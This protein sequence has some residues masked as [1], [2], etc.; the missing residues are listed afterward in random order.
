MNL[1]HTFALCCALTLA[2][3]AEPAWATQALDPID[4]GLLDLGAR[5]GKTAQDAKVLANAEA[6]FKAAAKHGDPE[7]NLYLAMTELALVEQNPAVQTLLNQLGVS[8][9]GRD[10]LNWKA[11]MPKNPKLNI[12][13]SEFEKLAANQLLT[14]LASADTK[15]AL[16]GS[17]FKTIHDLSQAGVRDVV[18]DY[19]DVSL[20][21][22]LIHA[23]SSGYGVVMTLISSS[24]TSRIGL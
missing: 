8:K 15:L 16:S 3:M 13:S 12:N 21:R 14:A 1:K 9:T 5:N 4:A 19:G 11:K 2:C 6:E 20:M 10:V 23:L 24:E 17:S 18:I 7:A 22:A